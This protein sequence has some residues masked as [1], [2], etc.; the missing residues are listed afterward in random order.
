MVADGKV[1]MKEARRYEQIR[2][3]ILGKIRDGV[4]PPGGRIPPERELA[5]ELGCS[6][7]TVRHAMGILTTEGVVTRQVGRGTFVTEHP[8]LGQE[9]CVGVLLHAQAEAYGG[10]ILNA[11]TRQAARQRVEL[12]IRGCRDTG[13]DAAAQMAR[14]SEQG[15]RGVILPWFPGGAQESRNVRDLIL[16]SPLPVSIAERIPGCEGNC[17]EPP[18]VF[19]SGDMVAVQT[20]CRYFQALGHRRIALLCPDQQDAPPV[21][22]RVA[23]YARYVSEHDLQNLTAMVGPSAQAVDETVRRWRQYAGALAVVAYDDTHALRLMTALHKQGLRIPEDV[24]VLGFNDSEPG[25]TSDPPLSSIANSY[26]YI[27][28][29]CLAHIRGLICGQ[30]TQSTNGMQHR[31]AVRESCGGQRLGRSALQTILQTL[32][33]TEGFTITEAIAIS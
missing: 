8:P 5:E 13:T 27:A 4:F 14:L 22:R 12:L 19:G 32:P 11:L 23:A 15:C 31:F 30:L 25:I 21:Q 2:D 28:R 16:Q 9:L 20:A 3:Y 17:I 33:L 18:E 6:F 1:I 7:H 24:A 29:A 10:S 26:D